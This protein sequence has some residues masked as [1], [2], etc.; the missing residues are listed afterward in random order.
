MRG[1]RAKKAEEAQVL[2][3]L[4]PKT[5]VYLVLRME[6]RGA[7]N[8]SAAIY[9][10]S[11]SCIERA[12]IL[13]GRAFSHINKSLRNLIKEFAE[14]SERSFDFAAGSKSTRIDFTKRSKGAI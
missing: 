6:I 5:A 11:V 9:P 10:L 2:T 1:K 13:F 12:L 4:I 7:D 14:L 8:T 3:S